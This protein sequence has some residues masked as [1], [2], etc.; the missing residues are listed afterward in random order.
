MFQ[1]VDIS[2][3]SIP[4]DIEDKLGDFGVR[5]ETLKSNSSDDVIAKMK[6]IVNVDPL[7][8]MKLL[9]SQGFDF[10]L[11]QACFPVCEIKKLVGIKMDDLTDVRLLRQ[12]RLLIE[13]DYC[14]GR[15]FVSDLDPAMVRLIHKV[16][17]RSD[18]QDFS[19]ILN[20]GSTTDEED[21]AAEKREQ[22]GDKEEEKK[23]EPD[24][25]VKEEEKKELSEEEDK[26]EEVE[27]SKEPVAKLPSP[28]KDAEKKAK[29]K[30][31]RQSKIKSV[32]EQLQKMKIATMWDFWQNYAINEKD[33]KQMTEE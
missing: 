26:K 23:G 7:A 8:F 30:A 16:P 3:L 12:V 17:D 11:T 25:E 22:E 33:K 15:D 2:K 4:R 32:K 28:Q 19:D 27:E 1:G 5:K 9:V 31:D 6:T 24:E 21:K 10:W 20:R 13:S 18:I 14:K 29:D